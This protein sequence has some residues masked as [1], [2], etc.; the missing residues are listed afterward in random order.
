VDEPL[1]R[2]LP[3][4]D[5]FVLEDVSLSNSNLHRRVAS[6]DLLRHVV[7]GQGAHDNVH[8]NAFFFASLILFAG[9]DSQQRT[10]VR[11]SGRRHRNIKG[12]FKTCYVLLRE[13]WM[14]HQPSTD[15]SMINTLLKSAMDPVRKGLALPDINPVEYSY[16]ITPEVLAT[17]NDPRCEKELERIASA[18]GGL[19]YPQDLDHVKNELVK[20]LGEDKAR[21]VIQ[22]L[23]AT[24]TREHLSAL[25][26]TATREAAGELY[27][28]LANPAGEALTLEGWKFV[29]LIEKRDTPH[30]LATLSQLRYRGAD[31]LFAF[32]ANKTGEVLAQFKTESSVIVVISR[33]EESQQVSDR[34]S[35]IIDLDYALCVY[36]ALKRLREDKERF[37][38]LKEQADTTVQCDS[39]DSLFISLRT[40]EAQ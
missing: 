36:L 24:E 20:L 12:N 39:F 18:S 38:R 26:I 3:G 37:A 34:A 28:S 10:F 17:V 1:Y 19:L 9:E 21:K 6:I 4:R 5:G 29:K 8:R 40:K 30:R 27:V 35:F 15:S 2:I 23:R 14:Q 33:D 11:R 7:N 32:K 31:S 16:A 25:S 22:V 13:L